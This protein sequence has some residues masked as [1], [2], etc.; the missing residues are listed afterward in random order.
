MSVL[1]SDRFTPEERVRDEYRIDSLIVTTEVLN[2]IKK[3]LLL[4]GIE[5]RYLGHHTYTECPGAKQRKAV[6]H[7]I[8]QKDSICT[9]KTEFLNFFHLCKC[10]VRG[11]AVG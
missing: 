11:G 3:T 1:C 5:P 2:K 8:I 4:P 9:V 6:I 10:G 7:K